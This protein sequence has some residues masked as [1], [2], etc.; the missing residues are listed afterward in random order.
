MSRQKELIELRLVSRMRELERDR[1]RNPRAP[2]ALTIVGPGRVGRAFAEAAGTAG[3]E[4][5]LLGRDSPGPGAAEAEALI[6][7]V[8]DAAIEPACRELAGGLGA[9]RFVGHT[10]GATGLDALS[11]A[12]ESGASVFSLH[13]LQTIRGHGSDLAGAFCAVS[14]SEDAALD[15]AESL[16]VS[17]GM[18]PFSVSEQK[19]AAYHAAASIAS[20]FL[21]AL[22]ESAAELLE[23]A[24][25]PEARRLLAPMVLRT[26][27]NW[28]EHGGAAL[29]GPIARG[30]AATVA[31]HLE[32][33]AETDPGLLDLYRAMAERT[34]A[35]TG[36]HA[37][38][39]R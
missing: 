26:A 31:R 30:D 35:L 25:V 36:G 29:T 5:T 17:L 19:R 1:D 33:L 18:S 4:V 39:V 28:A 2:A 21:V 20:N 9:I 38:A 13:P 16:A 14:A 27:A 37:E 8:P 6:L 32:A 22:E 11:A 34:V 7:C 10:S 15:F 3:I 23:N 24:G 12:S